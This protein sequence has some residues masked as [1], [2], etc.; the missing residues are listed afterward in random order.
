MLKLMHLEMRKITFGRYVIT[1]LAACFAVTG[2]LFFALYTDRNTVAAT[3]SDFFFV[4]DSTR[5]VFIVFAGV[6]ISRLIIEEY[7]DKTISLMFMY[8]ISR[9]KIMISKLL[10]IICATFFFIYVS[11]IFVA[12][13]LYMLNNY[14]NFI[15][16]G[17]AI[18]EITEYLKNTAVYDFSFSG[19]SLVP[20]FFGMLKKSVR[21]TIITSV[22]IAI[23]FG[24][25]N[26]ELSELSINSF[27]VRSLIFTIIG[28]I[29]SYLSIRNMEQKD[30]L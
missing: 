7:N 11:R 25:S 10:I 1:A 28:V 27:I 4:V 16:E 9:K 13:V 12:A 19:I 20:L 15:D 24:I 29:A 6:L 26:E 5:M 2:F 23:F 22:I 3:S 17:I 30:V 8:P 14:L 18:L 21:T